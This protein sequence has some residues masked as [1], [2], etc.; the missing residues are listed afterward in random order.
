MPETEKTH[1]TAAPVA[2]PSGASPAPI[3]DEPTEPGFDPEE[4]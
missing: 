3:E 4:Y 1:K 2:R